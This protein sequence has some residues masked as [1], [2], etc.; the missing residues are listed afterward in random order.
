MSH[1]TLVKIS[2]FI[3]GLIA[4]IGA[5]LFV[6]SIPNYFWNDG[7]TDLFWSSLTCFGVALVL[8]FILPAF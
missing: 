7:A 4:F 6:L 1:D 8:S 3:L 5:I 2:N